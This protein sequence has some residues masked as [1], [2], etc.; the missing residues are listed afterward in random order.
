MNTTIY[1]PASIA[2]VGVGFD[3][4]GAALAPIDGTRLGDCVS[5]SEGN[6]GL[7]FSC[8]GPWQHKLPADSRKNIVLQCAEYFL[9]QL[10]ADRQPAGLNIE[11][12]KN[13]PV[14]S[15]LGSSASSVVAAFVALNEF[16]GN[17]VAPNHLL[18]MMGDFEG[19]VSG[20]V[21][22]DNVAPAFLGGMQLMLQAAGRVCESI[23]VFEDWFWVVAYPGISLPTAEMRALLPPQ[24]DRAVTIDYGRNLG[25]FIHASY[26]HDQQLAAAVLKDVLAEPYRSP[27][28]PGFVE[29]RNA[30]TGLGMLATGISGSGPTIFSVTDNPDLAEKARQWLDQNFLKNSEG[31][32][33]VCRIDESG[34][35][36][37]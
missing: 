22:Y 19:R 12:N 28:I 2:N 30:M 29:A 21:H 3:L 8:S 14:G 26:R 10:P 36:R 9:A 13:L 24:Y 25:A 7:Q 35:R 15:G 34:A 16:F 1:A 11:L 23:P 27:S 37:L 4:L 17:F 33:R 32:S 6:Q 20:S 31:F 18:L 5:I